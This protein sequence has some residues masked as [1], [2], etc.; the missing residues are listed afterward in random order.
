MKPSP[1][2]SKEE[3]RRAQEALP[4]KE[5]ATRAGN[6]LAPGY[7]QTPPDEWWRSHNAHGVRR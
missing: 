6:A 2:I 7:P 5:D 3:W 1:I 4:A